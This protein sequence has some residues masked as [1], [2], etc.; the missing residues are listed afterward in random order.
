MFY[1]WEVLESTVSC[2]YLSF[3]QQASE[4]IVASGMDTPITIFIVRE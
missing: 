1:P 4:Y 3:T 2:K